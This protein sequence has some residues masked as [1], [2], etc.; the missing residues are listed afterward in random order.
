[1][2]GVFVDISGLSKAAVLAAL[3][4][5]AQPQ[6]MGFLHY[7]PKPWTE[8]DA[9]AYISQVNGHMYFDYVKGRV[10]KTDLSDDEVGTGLYNRDNGEGS[11]ER[12][13]D[14]LRAENTVLTAE[15]AVEHSE[16]VARER[17]A[18]R[19]LIGT[20]TQVSDLGPVRRV[21]LGSSPE[22]DEALE[23]ALGSR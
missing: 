1:M 22:L 10:I 5:N 23:V 20:P 21:D 12:V 9:A 18:A 19:A 3:Y 2:S 6:G 16:R 4:N 11:A 8:A 15:T 17:Q 14:I 7:D 13:I